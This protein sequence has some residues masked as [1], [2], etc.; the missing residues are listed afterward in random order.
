MFNSGFYPTPHEIAGRMIEPY[1]EKIR[2]GAIILDPSAGKGDLLT[3]CKHAGASKNNLFAIEIEPDL[4]AIIADKDFRLIGEDFLKYRSHYLFD[5]IVM[6]PP[7]S[8]GEEH[9]LTAWEILRRGDLVCLLNAASVDNPNT[10]MRELLSEII[11]QHGTVERLGQCFKS[12][13]RPTGVDVVMIRLHK[14]ADKDFFQFDFKNES[15]KQP[16]FQTGEVELENQ[17]ARADFISALVET[18]EQVGQAYEQFITAR[19]RLNF[20]V[21]TLKPHYYEKYDAERARRNCDS[22]DPRQ[23]DLAEYNAYMDW[24]KGAAWQTVFN[25]T[26]LRSVL[27]SKIRQDF[28]AFQ[29]QQ[30]QAE[31][32][33][34]NIHRLFEMLFV[35]RSENFQRCIVEVFDRMCAYDKKNRVHWEGWKTNDAYKVNQKVI[36]PWFVKFDVWNKFDQEGK[37]D[38]HYGNGE[39]LDDI[40]RALCLITGKPF[41]SIL[42]IKETLQNKFREI[43]RIKPNQEFSNV[44]FSEFFEM[45]FWK[46]GTLHFIFRDKFVWQEFNL[47]AAKGKNWLPSY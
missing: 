19:N 37:F 43:G 25:R 45:R 1:R 11:L 33:V 17:I 3:A 27:T 41:D 10:R 38:L 4:R 26:K 18:Y 22:K 6:N 24:L 14:E 34:E 28:E 42:R 40:D 20:Y 13:E 39:Q 30:G 32:T 5:L 46:K 44:A 15:R 8:D 9:V 12:A 21:D 16:D 23:K 29:R 47:R 35:N 2:N 36:M 7:F 31:F